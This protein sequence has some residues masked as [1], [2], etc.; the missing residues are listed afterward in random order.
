LT[1]PSEK[2]EAFLALLRPLQRPL[3]VYCRK[4]LRDLSLVEDV[5]QAAVAEAFAKF[6]RY[7]QGTNFRA[8]VFRFV[9]LEAF[10]RNRKREPAPC[11][12]ALR[13]LAAPPAAEGALDGCWPA[14]PDSALALFDDEVVA[15]LGQLTAPERAALLLRALGDFSYEEI[16]ELLGIP[17]GSVIGY[18][19]R[20]RQ[21]LRRS[22][23]DYAA[24]RGV[25]RQAAPGEARP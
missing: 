22:L 20:A 15:A 3:E 13:D 8:W 9:T 12:D 23:A 21:K 4:L 18:L 7:A 10:N 14:D 2:V 19:S 24:R 25:P 16:H 11:G 1:R 6:D 17:L 5:L